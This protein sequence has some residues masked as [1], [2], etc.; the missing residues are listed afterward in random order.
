MIIT[1]FDHVSKVYAHAHS[2][3]VCVSLL[4]KIT[5]PHMFD[6]VVQAMAHPMVQINMPERYLSPVQDLRLT[7][8]VEVQQEK[9]T[10]ML[11]P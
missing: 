11:L 3:A 9:I 7:M 10:K 8:T 4:G 5:D 2:M 1:L 6:A